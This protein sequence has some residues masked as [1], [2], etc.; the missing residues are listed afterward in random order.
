ME[1]SEKPKLIVIVRHA[2][3]LSN[4]KK[5]NGFVPAYVKDEFINLSAQNVPVTEKGE[6]QA[7]LTGKALKKLYGTFDYIYASPFT[8]TRQTRAGILQAYSNEEKAK[9][10][11]RE[12]LFLRERDAG[13]CFA[14]TR[15]ER[16]I[17]FPWLEQ[18]WKTHGNFWATPP[19]GESLAKITER[20]HQ[21]IGTPLLQHRKEQ[22]VL[23]I[24]H[25]G[26][27]RAIRFLLEKWT[28]EQAE[29][30]NGEGSPINCGV[31]TYRTDE[32]NRI[33]LESYN[34]KYW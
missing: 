23:I 6:N 11:L 31:T 15:E 16:D 18:Y 4:V 30:F 9:M 24:T 28:P 21:F 13:Y 32:E 17:N 3:S 1:R 25:G 19:G 26:T 8:R 29:I 14:M 34:K 20:V 22:K 5:E 12:S 33:L 2:E 27:L 7:V 10:Q